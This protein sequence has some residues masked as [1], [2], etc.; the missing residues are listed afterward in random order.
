MFFFLLPGW[1]DT[2]KELHR[3]DDVYHVFIL[4][5]CKQKFCI[6]IVIY[7]LSGHSSS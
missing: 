3:T 2:W 4:I 1:T 6:Q 7:S 5:L